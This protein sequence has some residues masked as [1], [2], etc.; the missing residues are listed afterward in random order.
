MPSLQHLLHPKAKDIGFPVRRLLPAVV[1][2]SV[3][4]FVFLDHM[5]PAHFPPD[6]TEGDVRPHPHIGLATLT[7]LFSGA[8]MHRD[9]LGTVQEITPGAV[10]LMAAGKGITHSERMPA[11]VRQDDA[12]VEGI[13]MWLALPKPLEE[14][15]PEFLHYPSTAMPEFNGDGIHLHLVMGSALGLTSPVKTYTPTLFA[16]LTMKAGSQFQ[17]P[18]DYSELAFYVVKGEVYTDQDEKVEA[19]N[20]GIAA[21]HDGLCLIAEQ[22]STL[23][24][25]G[26]EPLD[27]RRF[28]NWNFVSSRKERIEQARED[29]INQRFPTI[30][31]DDQEYIPLP[32]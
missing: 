4:P 2:Q 17:L 21:D 5:G 24:V 27:G 13:Q 28:L 14:M 30:P 20:L 22:D 16:A 10:N 8:I 32:R 18:A 12:A 23:I 29:W 26:G 9:S 19:F 11:H 7:Y 1:R 25:L 15:E 31:G 6:T 3:G